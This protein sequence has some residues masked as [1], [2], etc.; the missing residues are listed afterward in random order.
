MGDAMIIANLLLKLTAL[1]P[2][3]LL[4]LS[5]HFGAGMAFAALFYM[6]IFAFLADEALYANGEVG[7]RQGRIDAFLAEAV[8]LVLGLGH[9]ALLPLAVIF[10]AQGGQSLPDTLVTFMA[11]MLFFG[12]VSTANAHEMIHRRDRLRHHIGKWVLISIL[13]GHHTSAHMLVHHRYAATPRDPNSARVNEGVYRFFLRAWSGSFRCGL[14]AETARLAVN[15]RPALHPANP[16]FIYVV[17]ALVWLAGIYLAAG[18]RGVAIYLGFTTLAQMQLLL[19]D[20]VQHYGLQRRRL[21]NGKYEPVSI[22]HSW[23]AP[24][25]F[26][27]ALMLNAPKHSDHHAHPSVRYMHLRTRASEGAPVLPRSLPV[28]SCIAL[29]PG[30][31]K[32]LMNPLV[33]D[34]RRRH[35]ADQI[36]F[37]PTESQANVLSSPKAVFSG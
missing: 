28:M 19:S 10:I 21:A 15:G 23:N 11:F 14:N 26:T 24:H 34:W 13:F 8:P 2:M 25:A 31:W 20:Y 27:A 17:G 35:A 37:Q 16:Y 29:V 30:L 32:R 9:L 12:T 7:R 33:D 4:A 22:H 5:L 36:G 18:L 1:V 6:T 3:I